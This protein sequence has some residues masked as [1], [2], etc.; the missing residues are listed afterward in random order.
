[1]TA[2]VVTVSSSIGVWEGVKVFEGIAVGVAVSSAV[3]F[4][5]V[6]IVTDGVAAGAVSEAIGLVDSIGVK[7][8]GVDLSE[9]PANTS[10]NTMREIN[11]EN[12]ISNIIE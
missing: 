6:V 2:N 5:M 9:Q 4:T 10:K 12:F 1:M 8:S 7:I 11:R 3:G